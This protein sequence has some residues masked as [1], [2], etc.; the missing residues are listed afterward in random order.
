MMR[1]AR[2][3]SSSMFVSGDEY[4]WRRSSKMRIR[5]GF[6]IELSLS[7][8]TTVVTVM[9]VHPSRKPDVIEESGFHTDQEIRIQRFIDCFGNL[10]RRLT[11]EAGPLALKLVGA[12]GDS[13]SP[14][15]V[16]LSADA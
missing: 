1:G 9:D 2:Q 16:S 11:A 3:L 12:I 14:D 15:P 10:S 7:Q 5:Y 13:G 6:D 4:L 8:P